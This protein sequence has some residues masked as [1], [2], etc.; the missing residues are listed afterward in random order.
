MEIWV[1]PLLCVE[2]FVHLKYSYAN[3]TE[4]YI[5]L[6]C[7]QKIQYNRSKKTIVAKGIKIKAVIEY[8]KMQKWS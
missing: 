4:V 7:V 6:P 2:E 5:N 1:S 3:L 8:I